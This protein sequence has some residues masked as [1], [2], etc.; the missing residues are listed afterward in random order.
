MG[1]LTLGIVIEGLWVHHNF[2]VEAGSMHQVQF[3][4]L[5]K[6]DAHMACVQTVFVSDDADDIA[7]VDVGKLL[8]ASVQQGFGNILEDLAF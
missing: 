4:I 1:F 8:R 5:P 7:C 2:L 3:A 6:H